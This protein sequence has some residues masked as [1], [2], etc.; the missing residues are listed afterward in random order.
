MEKFDAIEQGRKRW[1]QGRRK[2]SPGCGT[3]AKGGSIRSNQIIVQRL[4]LWR[5]SILSDSAIDVP[6][7]ALGCPPTAQARGA[8]PG[9]R[10]ESQTRVAVDNYLHT[11]GFVY[12]QSAQSCA[13]ESDQNQDHRGTWTAVV[14]DVL[15]EAGQVGKPYT[16]S[17]ISQAS[18]LRKLGVCLRHRAVNPT[19][20]GTTRSLAPLRSTRSM[21]CML[22]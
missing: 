5:P 18:C 16:P 3:K 11:D 20:P 15:T 7:L 1:E 14:K 22:F 10:C 2:R 9:I 19:L 17:I 13:Q 12:S 6:G 21:W 8:R 4:T